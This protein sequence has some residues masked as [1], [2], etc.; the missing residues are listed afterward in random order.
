MTKFSIEMAEKLKAG[1]KEGISTFLAVAK[2]ARDETGVKGIA[3]WVQVA[4]SA[5]PENDQK[6]MLS[7]LI[8]TYF[9]I[10][11]ERRTS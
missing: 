9:E 7:M 6:I 5:L 4:F 2:I 10:D 8:D 1:G 11:E 3:E